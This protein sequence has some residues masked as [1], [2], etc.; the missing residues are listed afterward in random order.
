VYSWLA[1]SRVCGELPA[2]DAASGKSK[3][4]SNTS[5]YC[6]IAASDVPSPLPDNRKREGQRCCSVYSHNFKQ[7]FASLLK[8]SKTRSCPVTE[9]LAHGLEIPDEN[10]EEN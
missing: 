8:F 7:S 3:L 10:N 2:G 1:I 5:R 9:A 6:I 4:A